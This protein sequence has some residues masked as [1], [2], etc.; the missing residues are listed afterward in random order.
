MFGLSVLPGGGATGVNGAGGDP[1][2]DGLT[3]AEEF[4]RGS[5]PVGSQERF[6]AEGATG[7]FFTTRIAIANPTDIQ[8][9]VA[10][11]FELPAAGR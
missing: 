7:S 1:D 10:V 6:L 11:R 4:A 9:N 8:A 5:H 2:R 3:N